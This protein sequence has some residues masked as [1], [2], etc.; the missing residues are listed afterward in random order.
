VYSEVGLGLPRKNGKALALDTPIPTPD[1]WS[2]MGELRADD[3]V[4]DER[5]RPCRVVATSDVMLGRPCYRVSF[6]DGTAIV[7]DAEHEWLVEPRWRRPTVLTTAAMADRVHV[8]HRSTHREHRYRAPVAGPLDSGNGFYRWTALEHR[9]QYRSGGSW[10]IRSAQLAAIVEETGRLI[11]D[12]EVDWYVVRQTDDRV[13]ALAPRG[14]TADD[15][16]LDWTDESWEF[17]TGGSTCTPRAWFGERSVGRWRLDP[18]FP[19]PGPK[20]RRLHILGYLGCLGTER[21]GKAKVH[22]TDDVALI[23][24]PMRST[25][26]P[27]FGECL[28][29]TKMTIRLPEPLGRRTLYDAGSLPLRGAN[30]KLDIDR[31]NSSGSGG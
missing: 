1:G 24:I 21:A 30:E 23:A 5:G 25:V 9:Y 19:A 6:S 11:A 17:Q 4:F 14:R 15:Q 18:A 10:T 12:R 22:M 28:S 31:I 27:H 8:G 16:L 20:T 2:T 26:G 7:A 13:L 3:T 29:P